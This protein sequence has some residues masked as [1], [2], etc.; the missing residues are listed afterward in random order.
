MYIIITDIDGQAE[1]LKGALALLTALCA[2]ARSRQK[3]IQNPAPDVIISVS[4]N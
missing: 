2:L 3:M 1:K 4:T